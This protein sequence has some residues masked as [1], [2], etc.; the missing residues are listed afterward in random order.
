MSLDYNLIF[1]AY[2]ELILAA[3]P[4]A[5]FIFAIGKAINIFLSMAFGRE[6]VNL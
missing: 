3:G 6:R 2:A 5:I 1:S 4:V